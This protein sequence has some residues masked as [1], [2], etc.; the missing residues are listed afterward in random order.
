M[1][2]SWRKFFYILLGFGVL[3]VLVALYL[4]FLIRTVPAIYEKELKRPLSTYNEPVQEFLEAVDDIEENLRLGDD[5][6]Y[7]VTQE[8]I[9]GWLATQLKGN[10]RVSLPSGIESPRLL[11]EGKSQMIYFTIVRP[12]LLYTSPS[13]RD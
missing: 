1:K 6:D 3:V 12:C 9:N 11:L 13:P 7:E 4:M 5:F 8:Q 10:S 2:M